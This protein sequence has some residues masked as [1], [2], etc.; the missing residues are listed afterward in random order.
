MST[1]K[2]LRLLAVAAMVTT[3]LV[4][5]TVAGASGFPQPCNGVV[6]DA[7]NPS[8]VFYGSG[9]ANG[10][11]VDRSAATGPQIFFWN[12]SG[13][14]TLTGSAF[15]DVICGTTSGD[16]IWGGKGND[17]IFGQGG[18]DSLYGNAGDDT[19]FNGGFAGGLA[20]NGPG[21]V[22]NG[23]SASLYGKKGNDLIYTGWSSDYVKG[24]SGDDVI[25]VKDFGYG[26]GSTTY[27]QK[28]DDTWIGGSVSAT[29]NGGM[30]NDTAIFG[31]GDS[32]YA[33][34]QK[35]M[36][37]LTGGTGLGQYLDGG[38]DND[39][40][41]AG[42]GGSQS[43]YGGRGND[44]LSNLGAAASQTAYGEGGND[45]IT[46]KTTG[47]LAFIAGGNA[48]NDVIKGGAA[49]DSLFGNSGNDQIWG[50]D[51][52]DYISGGSGSDVMYGNTPGPGGLDTADGDYD[53]MEASSSPLIPGVFGAPDTPATSNTFY[54]ACLDAGDT[55]DATGTGVDT[56]YN[57][58]S[59]T[60]I[61][62][63]VNGC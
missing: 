46:A 28:G 26:S 33:Y 18:G 2:S 59:N 9:S 41:T 54:G 45:T 63:V 52:A 13:S 57:T 39:T 55:A 22:P 29:F 35:G 44:T 56:A 31:S 4:S 7:A 43:L 14:A 17:L 34:G 25:N 23:S 40:L 50:G 37:T 48:D 53:D 19:I 16:T 21:S 61:E 62:N 51:G 49:G 30:G 24:G 6:F 5:A 20:P 11:I 8:H 27:G 12:G 38:N 10:S 42:A 60:G 32:Q 3:V 47:A 36:D 58:S 15:D 1:R